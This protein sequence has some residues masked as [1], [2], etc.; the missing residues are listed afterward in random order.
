MI[1]SGDVLLVV[2]QRSR[3]ASCGPGSTLDELLWAVGFVVGSMNPVI[4]AART[5]SFRCED[6]SWQSIIARP[7]RA[8]CFVQI[9]E[10]GD[11]IHIVKDKW[12]NPV[13][14]G[15]CYVMESLSTLVNHPGG[16]SSLYPANGT[17][18]YKAYVE[19]TAS[20]LGES[21]LLYETTQ[22]SR[23]ILNWPDI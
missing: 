4:S 23:W 16:T 12:S 6:W 7:G 5:Y 17:L 11:G 3:A 2:A 9:K 22:G 18:S 1:G 20:S 21:T 19:V 10:H 13:N 8:T 15:I 14:H